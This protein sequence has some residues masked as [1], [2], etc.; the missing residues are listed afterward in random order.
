MCLTLT[1][2]SRVACFGNPRSSHD[3][4][5]VSAPEELEEVFSAVREAKRQQRAEVDGVTA[6]VLFALW[7]SQHLLANATKVASTALV[8]KARQRRG[9]L[10]GRAD[11]AHGGGGRGGRTVPGPRRRGIH[12]QGG[13]CAPDSGP[14]MVWAVRGGVPGRGGGSAGVVTLLSLDV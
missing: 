9:V 7:W 13:A 10:G 1:V 12:D 8:V 2:H 14:E 3:V 4:S 5:D 11:S 6:A